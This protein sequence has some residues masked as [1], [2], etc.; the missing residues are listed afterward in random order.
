MLTREI[1]FS[2]ERC[3]RTLPVDGDPVLVGE[4]LTNLIE[5]ALHHGG[6]GMTRIAVRTLWD[7][8][9]CVV[10]VQ[11]DGVGIPPEQAETAFRRFSQLRNG[12]GTGLGL[13]IVEQ[14]VRRHDGSVR[15][16][17]VGKGTCVRL[18]LPAAAPRK[19]NNTV[20]E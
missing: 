16:T 11:D 4:A 13:A 15:L 12:A 19:R 17:E 10:T 2:L 9:A 8:G 20:P 5:N 6:D 14:V 18:T 3:D 7:G 1:E